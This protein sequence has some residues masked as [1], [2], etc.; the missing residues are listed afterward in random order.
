MLGVLERM[1]QR[2][3]L[4]RVEQTYIKLGIIKSAETNTEMKK[5]IIGNLGLMIMNFNWWMNNKHSKYKNACD[6]QGKRRCGEI[7]NQMKRKWKLPKEQITERC[8]E[9]EMPMLCGKIDEGYNYKK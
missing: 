5:K 9:V 3:C 6:N 1:Q 4:G 2:K 8:T 7:G